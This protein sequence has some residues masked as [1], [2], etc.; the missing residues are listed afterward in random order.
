MLLPKTVHV[1][2]GGADEVRRFFPIAQ[3]ESRAGTAPAY[4]VVNG[5]LHWR[6]AALR[7]WQRDGPRPGSDATQSRRAL[8]AVLNA[9]SSQGISSGPNARTSLVS[10]E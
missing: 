9:M 8:S 1:N 6:P 3:S 5:N 7:V 2:L 4:T 10:A